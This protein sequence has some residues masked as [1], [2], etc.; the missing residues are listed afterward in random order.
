MLR[1]LIK[2]L[3]MLGE[4]ITKSATTSYAAKHHILARDSQASDTL[5]LKVERKFNYLIML[6]F[7]QKRR[8]KPPSPGLFV[9]E[10]SWGY[11]P[12]AR[13]GNNACA[14]FK[15]SGLQKTRDKATTSSK[16]R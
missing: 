9:T 8:G 4:A 1:F 15:C 2:G 13:V 11:L 3:T 6:D 14:R 5:T 16:R 12:A 7:H 10:I